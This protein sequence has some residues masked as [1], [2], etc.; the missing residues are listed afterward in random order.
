MADFFLQIGWEEIPALMIDAAR[1]ELAERVTE[2]L[3]K[4]YLGTSDVRSF[5]T[6]RRISVSSWV[7]TEQPTSGAK[8][9]GPPVSVARKDGKWTKAAEAFAEKVGTTVDQLLEE[10]TGKGKYL[11]AN[12]VKVGR[13]SREILRELLPSVITKLYWPKSM[14]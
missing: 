1:T 5:S 3:K 14:Y 9:L 8:I 6:P 2:L 4:E 13:P 12:V 7:A 10:E 11:V